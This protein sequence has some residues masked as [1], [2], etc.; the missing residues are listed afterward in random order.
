MLLSRISDTELKHL[1]RNSFFSECH[2]DVIFKIKFDNLQFHPS[3]QSIFTSNILI[4]IHTLL[5]SIAE[6]KIKLIK[7]KL[8]FLRNRLPYYNNN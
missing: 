2:I 6:K 3:N 5:Q 1:L 8:S 4:F 7:K